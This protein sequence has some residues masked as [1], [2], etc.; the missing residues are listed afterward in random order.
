MLFVVCCLLLGVCGSLFVVH[1]VLCVA[2][3]LLIV[4]SCSLFVVWFGFVALVDLFGVFVSYL[5]VVGCRSRFG[6][7]LLLFVV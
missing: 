1:C 6:V 4:A 2:C 3:C 7:S 5:L